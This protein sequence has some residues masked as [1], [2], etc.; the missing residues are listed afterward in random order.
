MNYD[1]DNKIWRVLG[2]LFAYLGIRFLVETIFYVVLWNI[3]FKEL[4]VSAAF[5][6]ILYVEEYSDYVLGYTLVMTLIS[7]LVSIPIM[8]LMVKKDY[9]YPVNPRRKEKKFIFK[10]YFEKIDVK[11]FNY[12][13]ILGILAPLGIGRFIALLPIDGI[14]GSYKNVQSNLAGSSVI[15]QFLVLGILTPILEELLFRG[16]IYKRLKMYCDVSVAAY[17]A[18]IIFAIAH[19]NL[20]QGLYAFIL[21]IVLSYIYEKNG[22]LVDTMVAHSA[23]NMVSVVMGINPLSKFIDRYILIRIIVSIVMIGLF[24]MVLSRM[25]QKKQIDEVIIDEMIIDEEIIDEEIIDE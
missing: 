14:L 18:A 25:N 1:R 21:G 24:V 9:E 10:D 16:V 17:I 13:I 15:L 4:N 5:N 7:L 8:Y 6:G 22:S 11:K 3:K 19:F 12:P 20:I 23:A 2:P